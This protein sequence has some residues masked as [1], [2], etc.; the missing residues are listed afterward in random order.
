MYST[1]LAAVLP[2]LA[3]HGLSHQRHYE[4]RHGCSTGG[5][6]CQSCRWNGFGTCYDY[7]RYSNYPWHPPRPYYVIPHAGPSA[8]P[9]IIHITPICPPPPAELVPPPGDDSSPSDPR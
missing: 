1:L 4:Y 5:Q 8:L 9:D 3:P 7:R 6:H 2:I